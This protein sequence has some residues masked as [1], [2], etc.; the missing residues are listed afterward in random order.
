[1]GNFQFSQFMVV[2]VLIRLPQPM[3]KPHEGAITQCIRFVSVASE[4]GH[5]LII[6]D[7]IHC[8]SGLVYRVHT[9]SHK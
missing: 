5:L 1:M 2:A 4:C 9:L 7:G 3:I 8:V 6:D